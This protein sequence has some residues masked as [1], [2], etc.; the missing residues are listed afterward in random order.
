[1]RVKFY[2]LYFQLIDKERM[3]NLES[4]EIMNLNSNQQ[5]TSEQLMD[6]WVTDM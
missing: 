3:T 4:N 5:I 1:M 2:F 6:N